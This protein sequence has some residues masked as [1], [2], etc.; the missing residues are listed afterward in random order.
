MAEASDLLPEYLRP[1]E[2]R[3]MLRNPSQSS[4]SE[5]RTGHKFNGVMI[6]ESQN[7]T[8]GDQINVTYT[9]DQEA[10]RK[11]VLNW[12]SPRA[13][14]T[15]FDRLRED[16]CEGVGVQALE[17]PEFCNWYGGH[18]KWPWCYGMPGAGKTSFATIAID[19]IQK[20]QSTRPGN[21]GLA[22]IYFDHE[23]DKQ[24]ALKFLRMILRQLVELSPTISD[25]VMSLY[26]DNK[27]ARRQS[28]LK[29]R[30][31]KG[32]LRQEMT[33]FDTIYIVF[34][35]LDE[36]RDDDETASRTDTRHDLL[37]ALHTLG[38]KYQFL[39]TSRYDAPSSAGVRL[40]DP[41]TTM[42][43][44][45]T[46]E[47]ISEFILGEAYQ[48]AYEKILKTVWEQDKQSAGIAQT[49]ISWLKFTQDPTKVTLPLL[50]GAFSLKAGLH[51]TGEHT[52][53]SEEDLLRVCRGVVTIDRFTERVRFIHYTADTDFEDEARLMMDIH[54]F[55]FNDRPAIIFQAVIDSLNSDWKPKPGGYEYAGLEPLHIAAYFGLQQTA[56]KFLDRGEDIEVK[57]CRGWTPMQWA[58]VG[59]SRD[60]VK[61]LFERHASLVSEDIHGFPA[62]FWA[63]GSRLTE[64]KTQYI[65]LYDK[66]RLVYG[67]FKVLGSR[68]SFSA[69]LPSTVESRTSTDVLHFLLENLPDI[70]IR[71]SVD[72][73]TLLSV[74]AEN[75]QW[76]ALDI[77]LRRKRM[78]T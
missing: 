9:N 46:H 43:I 67:E 78:S 5:P 37:D 22:H 31:C 11:E 64:F 57:D 70:D 7:T 58:I 1:L 62:V 42:Q 75:W 13:L 34:D 38:E 45:A 12:L 32:L 66:A 61:M 69:A 68:L 56:M 73:R 3:N 71:R 77:L 8:L 52:G 4:V 63:V 6:S 49:V 29:S 24:S 76:D 53:I 54:W 17:R 23:D 47:D 19:H 21:I 14:E 51:V 26:N 28:I 36:C 60:L 30:E 72:E 50:Q 39:I 59:R 16:L 18:Q 55:D 10:I 74:V 33:R 41:F 35:A 15:P 48:E 44:S 2:I 40:E 65:C 25:E 20:A 27:S